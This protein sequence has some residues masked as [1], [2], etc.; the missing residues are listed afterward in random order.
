VILLFERLVEDFH[1]E[2]PSLVSRGRRNLGGTAA[3]ARTRHTRFIDSMLGILDTLDL[4]NRGVGSLSFM[5]AMLDLHL[6]SPLASNDLV[7]TEA[8]RLHVSCV[9]IRNLLRRAEERDWLQRDRR[10]LSLSPKGRRRVVT[11]MESFESVA[12]NVLLGDGGSPQGTGWWR[13][14]GEP[15]SVAGWG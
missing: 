6:Y 3:D 2:A 1:R 7:R 13:R 10:M 11:A 4:G 12:A 5:L 8:K 14:T 9:T 15:M